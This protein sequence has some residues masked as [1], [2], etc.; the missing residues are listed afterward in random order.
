MTNDTAS[1]AHRCSRIESN[2]EIGAI[3]DFLADIDAHQ[4]AALEQLC[5]QIEHTAR[6]YLDNEKL[7]AEFITKQAA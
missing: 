5:D 6:A 3:V 1:L 7:D 2:T 4:R